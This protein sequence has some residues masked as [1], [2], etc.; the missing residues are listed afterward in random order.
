V[1]IALSLLWSLL[2][3]EQKVWQPWPPVLGLV[4]ALDFTLFVRAWTL[5]AR[6][7]HHQ[8]PPQR[9]PQSVGRKTPF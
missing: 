6:A 9:L 7:L 8:R 4:A 1:L 5:Y 2:Y 3:L